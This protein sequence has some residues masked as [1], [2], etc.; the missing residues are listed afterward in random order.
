MEAGASWPNTEGHYER[1]PL[2]AVCLTLQ[3]VGKPVTTSA[4]IGKDILTR[5]CVRASAACTAVK[6]AE[7]AQFQRFDDSQLRKC[8]YR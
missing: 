5:G 4:E 8:C 6:L 2:A 7:G 3:A 1:P